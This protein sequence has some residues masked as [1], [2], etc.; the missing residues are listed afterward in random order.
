MTDKLQ[1]MLINILLDQ[2][3]NITPTFP[4]GRIFFV[5]LVMRKGG[6]NS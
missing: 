6:K 3:L 2:F 4:F 1:L 5:V